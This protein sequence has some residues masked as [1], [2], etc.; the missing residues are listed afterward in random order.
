MAT[1]RTA[2]VDNEQSD[3][4]NVKPLPNKVVNNHLK[5][6]ID[7]LKTF[8]PLTANQKKFFDAY[9]LGDY[10]IALHGV[11]GTGKKIGRAHV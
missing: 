2:K 4:T 1:K 10:F 7:D 3:T 8:E 6:R 11:A 9:K 5:I